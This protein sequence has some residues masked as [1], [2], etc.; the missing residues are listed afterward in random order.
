M[1]RPRSDVVYGIYRGLPSG[2]CA[3]IYV[4]LPH[5]ATEQAGTAIAWD[6]P[7]SLAKCPIRIPE[8]PEIRVYELDT[9]LAKMGTLV[10][11]HFEI[12]TYA[13]RS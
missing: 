12:H 9:W 8:S 6:P 2:V 5:Y 3:Y 13:K 7:S 10:S 4:D 1:I 11:T